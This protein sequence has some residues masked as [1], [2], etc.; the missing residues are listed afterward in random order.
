MGLF[1]VGRLADR[2]GIRVRLRGLS[3]EQARSGYDGR[4]L[5]AVD[6][7]GRRRRWPRCAAPRPRRHAQPSSTAADQP[8]AA[9]D[10]GDSADLA[11]LADTTERNGSHS[12]E[13]SITLLPRRRPGSS[14]I[15]GVPAD[16]PDRPSRREPPLRRREEGSRADC[17]NPC[18]PTGFEHVVVLRLTGA[19]HPPAA[20]QSGAGRA[21][22]GRAAFDVPEID[23]PWPAEAAAPSSEP[24]ETDLIYQRML[25]E[26]LVDPHD[27]ARSADLDWKSVWDRGW[28]A[29]AEVDNVPV[30]A[31][32]DHGLPVREPGARLVPGGAGPEQNGI[33]DRTPPRR[34]GQRSSIERR[35]PFRPQAR[36]RGAGARPRG[37]PRLDEQPF[38]RRSRRTIACPR[39]R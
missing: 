28:S 34:R 30:Q 18:G 12:T 19:I 29:A 37:D 13:S 8:A 35:I 23:E 16:Q 1:V 2:H 9:A 33:A 15:T 26:W 25:S 6:G 10:Y 32:T 27:L 7:V 21:G 39:H 3:T 20:S 4:G 14:G 17:G 11:A 38:R 22:A 24:P 31:H 5:S 36:T